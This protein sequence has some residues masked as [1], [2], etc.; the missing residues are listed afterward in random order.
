MKKVKV[1]IMGLGTVGG[2]TYEALTKNK[3]AILRNYGAEIEV[4]AIL[5]RSEEA[6]AAKGADKKL[7]S[8]IDKILSDDE[9]SIVVET[10]GGLEPAGTFV[11]RA[12]K[13]GKSVV[14]ANKELLAKR[15]GELR[16]AAEEG[17]AGL[18]FEASCVGGVPIIRTLTDAM[19]ANNITEI[20]GI[21]NG[22]TN[23]ILT[24][25]TEEKT[26][27][28]A[29]LKQ[30]QKLGYAEADPTAD[31][32]GFDAAYKL[33]ILASLAFHKHI[34]I[35]SVYREGISAV[36]ERDIAVGENMG[37][38]LKLLAVGRREQTGEIQVRVHPA[39][40]PVSHPLASVRG[41][42]N[43]VLLKG[44][45]VDEIMLYGRGA[46]ARPTASAVVSDVVYCA[47]ADRPLEIFYDDAPPKMNADFA[48][49]YYLSIT[50]SDKPGML[51]GISGVLGKH[52]ISIGKMLQEGSR[53]E[54]ADIILL[55]HMTSERSMQSAVAELNALKGV[56]KVNSLI[57]VIG[58]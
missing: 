32:D 54:D 45:F 10:M 48:S 11:K 37:Y 40:V 46:G 14:T 16:A 49:E 39:F 25:M 42:F 5:D 36:T 53:G 35:D 56:I 22:T 19:Q 41:S 13:A 24:Q 18:Y 12:L 27:Y 7:F 43:A 4:K 47:L 31:V 52:G 44:D 30:A 28:A 2:G 34:S 26:S 21:I 57:R 51:S 9:I 38:V 29:A 3:E 23:Y 15:G 50:A 58:D 55:T 1:A 33:S 17:G 8:D 6:L 20:T